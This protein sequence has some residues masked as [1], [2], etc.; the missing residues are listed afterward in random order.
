MT[1]ALLIFKPD[2]AHRLGPRAAIWRFLC[3]RPDIDIRGLKWF[4]P[5]HELIESHYDFLAGRPF[6][7]WLIEFM[8]VLPVVVGIVRAEPAAL[9]QLRQDLGET[10][11][12][13]SRPGSIRERFGIYGGINCLHLSDSPESAERETANWSK[14]LQLE[15]VEPLPDQADAP[16]HTYHLRSLAAQLAAGTH[17]E[18]ARREIVRLLGEETGLE[19]ERLERYSRVIIEGF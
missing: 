8:T 1:D 17:V 14:H 5:P 9:E 10:R 3:D 13:Q 18:V 2:S 19:G 4:S 12:A 11:I 6:F 7:P 16:D 15:G